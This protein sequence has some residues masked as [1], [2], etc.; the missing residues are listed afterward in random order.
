LN[1][2]TRLGV[3]G[4]YGLT[5]PQDEDMADAYDVLTFGLEA[6]HFISENLMAYGQ[7]GWGEKLRDGQDSDEAFNGGPVA[8]LGVSYFA[9]KT[10]ALTLD[11]EVAGTS[12]FVDEGDDGRFYGATLSYQQLVAQDLPLYLTCFGR[13]D[14]I[15]GT[16]DGTVEEWQLGFGLRYFFGAGSPQDAARKGLSIGTPRLPTRASAW[17]EYLD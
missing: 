6:Q 10:S 4:G 2:D 11:L 17:T 3:F 12:K 9:T 16:D 8:R 5:V 13:Y 7:L 1:E 15:D 14:L